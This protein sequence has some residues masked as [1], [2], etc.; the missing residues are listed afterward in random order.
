[1]KQFETQI[2]RVE[3]QFSDQTSFKVCL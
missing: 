2:F 3:K 1:M